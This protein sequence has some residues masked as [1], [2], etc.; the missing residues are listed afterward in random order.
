MME[1]MNI[2]WLL[3]AFFGLIS[4]MILCVALWPLLTEDHSLSRERGRRPL[5]GLL[6]GLI[7]FMS[8][9]SSS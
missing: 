3:S 4:I 6:E 2:A 5:L 7:A 9:D 8:F 1:G